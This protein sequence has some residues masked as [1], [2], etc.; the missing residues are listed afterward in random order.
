MKI[1]I[2]GCSGHYG[3]A[4]DGISFNNKYTIVGISPGVE[5]ENIDK[6]YEKVRKDHQEVRVYKDYLRM[7]EELNPEIA[8]VNTYCT[9]NEEIVI[10]LLQR[11]IHLFIE[12]P[13]TTSMDSLCKI[14]D[15]YSKSKSH[16]CS[17]MGIRYHAAF[18]TAYQIVKE[19]G[20]G[21]VKLINAQKSYKLGQRGNFYEKRD[22][23]GGILQ[24]VGIH[25]IDWIYYFSGQE[26]SSVYGRSS[27]LIEKD[28]NEIEMSGVC[29]FELTNGVYATLVTDF[30]RPETANSHDDDRLRVVGTKGIIEVRDNQVFVMSNDREGSQEIHLLEEKNIFEDFLESI[31]GNKTCFVSS[32][33]VFEVTKA[34][35]YAKESAD[36]NKIM[37]W[38]EVN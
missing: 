15:A 4:L 9:K 18:L 30:Y 22:Y 27:E 1:V 12:K 23:Y 32:A 19:G 31:E 16:L 10:N 5:E 3:Y 7:I 2:I 33:E 14:K 20:I 35:I 25:G 21:K 29:Q 38:N 11:D 28:G 36:H 6:I 34:S 8:V 17:M 13:L 26:F 24:W 37:F